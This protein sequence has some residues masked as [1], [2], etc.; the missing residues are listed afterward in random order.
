MRRVLDDKNI[1]A[2]SIATCDHW[3][4][5]AAIWACQAGK[6]VYVEKPISHNIWEGRRIIDAARKYKRVVAPGTQNR[7]IA[8]VCAA[9]QFLHDGGIGDV[10][11]ARALCFK[12][13]DTIGFMQN[14]PVPAGVD[15]DLWLGPAPW[16][17]FNPNRF[18]Y[19]WHW[20][21]D[22]GM[23]DIGNQGPHQMDIA[24]WGL[25]KDDYPKKIKSIGGYYAFSSQQE[26]PNTQIA[27]FEYADGKILQFETRGIYTNTEEG[28]LIGNLFYG[29]EGWM[30]INGDSWATFFGR[31]NEP[32]PSSAT[33]G[34]IADPGNLAGA[35]GSAH[36]ANF[37]EAV[38]ADDFT[39]L[40]ADI[41]EGHRSTAMVHLADI[42]YRTGRELEFDTYTET[43]P[44]DDQANG[45]LRRNF[46]HPF[47]V[48]E[49]VELVFS[50]SIFHV[51]CGNG[52]A[53]T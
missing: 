48:P 19:N 38:R 41:I 49:D 1:D 16:R 34:D 33:T 42:S 44:G 51:I 53:V 10:Y 52:T 18:H 28:V 45:Y 2:V 6:H 35:G 26:T 27:L 40:N 22:Y 46:R 23:P 9:M 5:L 7:S 20:Y 43:F 24:R 8:G 36:F 21:W 29:S 17:P 32:G 25:Q 11:M 31:K 15:Y 4:A 12:P 14:E 30:W 37:I 3:H 47:V 50:S 13:R 39:K